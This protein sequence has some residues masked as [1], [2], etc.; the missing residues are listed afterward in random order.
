MGILDESCYTKNIL[1]WYLSFRNVVKHVDSVIPEKKDK[2]IVKK[3]SH[4]YVYYILPAV[5][6]S[7]LS[8]GGYTIYKRYWVDTE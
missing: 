8:Y 3:E 6:L 4:S 5:F 7:G 1:D 2:C